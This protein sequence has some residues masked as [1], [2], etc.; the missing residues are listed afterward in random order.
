MLVPKP[1]EV[2][3]ESL[4]NIVIETLSGKKEISGYTYGTFER[5]RHIVV[6]MNLNLEV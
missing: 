1:L 3:F 2:D 5:K 6:K 4:L